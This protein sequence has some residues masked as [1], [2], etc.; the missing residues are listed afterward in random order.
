MG[1]ENKTPPK[2]DTQ[3]LRELH[4][5]WCNFGGCYKC[6]HRL[7]ECYGDDFLC[8]F[9]WIEDRQNEPHTKQA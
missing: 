8:F 2:I 4:Q 7:E 9:I 5:E 6:K 3:Y 1:K